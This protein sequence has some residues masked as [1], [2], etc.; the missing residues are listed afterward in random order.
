MVL[1]CTIEELYLIGDTLISG[2]IKS[3]F[4]LKIY[5]FRAIKQNQSH[6]D[7]QIYKVYFD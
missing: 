3:E 4:K 2:N 7:A 5:A 1:E 6:K